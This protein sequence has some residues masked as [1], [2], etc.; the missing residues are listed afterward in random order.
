MLREPHD[1]VAVTVSTLV[2]A[3]GVVLNVLLIIVV[4]LGSPRQIKSVLR[5]SFSYFHS[6]IS[7]F[8]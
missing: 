8:E 1:V 2:N 4:Q 3:P 5:S 6:R 7:Y